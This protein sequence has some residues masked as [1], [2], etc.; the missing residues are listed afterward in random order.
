MASSLL[1]CMM[2]RERERRKERKRKKLSFYHL[3][4][5]SSSVCNDQKFQI[6]MWPCNIYSYADEDFYMAIRVVS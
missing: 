5:M 3:G 4:R 1:I 6:F 2:K